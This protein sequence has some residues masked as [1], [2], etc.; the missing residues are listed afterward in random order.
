MLSLEALQPAASMPNLG[1]AASLCG[2]SKALMWSGLP[3]TTARCIKAKRTGDFRHALLF[4]FRMKWA[5]CV[6]AA[7]KLL[8]ITD[9]AMQGTGA[10]LSCW[11][12]AEL[13][14]G[15]L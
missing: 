10:Q 5:G 8:G 6:V 3:L 7:V 1:H 12:P 4:I 13:G 9:H 11:S 15:P 2:S 14:A